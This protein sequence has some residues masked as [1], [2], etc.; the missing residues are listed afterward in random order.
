MEDSVADVAEESDG[1]MGFI[2]L[3]GRRLDSG[4]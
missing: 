4:G 1:S 2:G 3:P